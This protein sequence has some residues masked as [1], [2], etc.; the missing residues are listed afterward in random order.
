MTGRGR[1]RVGFTCAS[2]DGTTF[3]VWVPFTQPG[4]GPA[5]APADSGGDEP[6]EAAVRDRRA[7]AEEAEGW[8]EGD[9]A[10][11]GIVAAPA[12]PPVSAPGARSMVLVVDDADLRR[13]APS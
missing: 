5:T 3:T 7:S 8:M 2:G 13:P 6:T 12:A 1:R 10:P 9:A 4:G 11:P